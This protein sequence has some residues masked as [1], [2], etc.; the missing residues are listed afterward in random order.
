MNNYS[1]EYITF[2][3]HGISNTL[4]KKT[5]FKLI[6]SVKDKTIIPIYFSPFISKNITIRY[7]ADNIEKIIGF[8][9]LMGI[10]IGQMS[11]DI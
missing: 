2:L 3:E 7:F 1:C 9:K 4:M 11:Y 5:K 8:L 6:N 10:K